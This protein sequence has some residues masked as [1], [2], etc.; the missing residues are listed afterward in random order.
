MRCGLEAIVVGAGGHAKVVISSLRS[1]GWGIRCVYDD[2]ETKWNQNL[3]GAVVTG[4]IARL[5]ERDRLPAVIA[6]GDPLFR[7][8][9]AERY[10][11]DWITLVHP[12]AHVDDSAVIGPGT[13]IFA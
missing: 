11:R 13:V 5:D 1:M 7:K 2:D 9:L 10:D 8:R 3:L 12:R 6:V 4:P